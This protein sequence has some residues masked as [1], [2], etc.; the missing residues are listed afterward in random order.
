[1]SRSRLGRVS[2]G[3]PAKTSSF[4]VMNNHQVVEE[5][6]ASCPD[7]DA[8][9]Y[10]TH[11]AGLFRYCWFM[12]T[13]TGAAQVALRDCLIV[14]DAHRVRMGMRERLLACFTDPELAG[15]GVAERPAAPGSHGSRAQVSGLARPT[16]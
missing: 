1:M 14:A 13:N 12:L 6:R 10:D 3:I 11:A 2:R 4:L 7:T 8:A 9:V 5:A 15:P 16:S